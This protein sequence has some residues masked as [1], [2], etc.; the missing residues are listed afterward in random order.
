MKVAYKGRH[1]Y[2]LKHPDVYVQES[3]SQAPLLLPF[4][5]TSWKSANILLFP[6]RDFAQPS[7]NQTLTLTI[8]FSKLKKKGRFRGWSTIGLADWSDQSE[9]TIF[10]LQHLL[11]HSHTVSHRLNIEPNLDSQLTNEKRGW[12]QKYLV[13]TSEQQV[14]VRG[15]KLASR[16]SFTSLRKFCERDWR[17]A[18]PT[19][20]NSRIKRAHFPEIFFSF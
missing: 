2:T 16:M 1:F 3:K 20:E 13:E 12:M 8:S 18:L 17:A 6:N 14:W 9:C 7:H 4:P 15:A 5:Q 11:E 10:P 19:L